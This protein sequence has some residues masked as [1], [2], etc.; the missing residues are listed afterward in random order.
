MFT[1]SDLVTVAAHQ[2][3]TAVSI[4][5]P[6]HTSGSDVR[7]DLIRL[8]NLSNRARDLL[9]DAGHERAAAEDILRPAKAFVDDPV[10][11]QE[12][13]AGFALFL[14]EKGEQARFSVPVA[15]PE[16]V[17]VGTRFDVTP[18]LPLVESDGQFLVLTVTST[19]V[20][21]YRASR[22]ELESLEGA[23]LPASLTESLG[24]VEDEDTGATSPTGSRPHT[25][26]SGTGTAQVYGDSPRD[27]RKIRLTEFASRVASAL[28]RHVGGTR[29][30]VVLV[31]NAELAGLLGD[32][33][34]FDEK[35]ERNP[36]A[37]SSAELRALAYGKLQDH[38]DE[39]RRTAVD[40]FESLHGKQ[41][42]RAL[43]SIPAITVAATEG[44]VD[45]LL[46]RAAPPTSEAPNP[47]GAPAAGAEDGLGEA[48]S[49]T[50]AHGGKVH[51][52]P[53]L[54]GAPHASAAAILRY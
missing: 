14:T 52:V 25:G 38:L 29:Q 33:Y 44:R 17:T 34:T 36:E 46:V 28:E 48:I 43:D 32:A 3:D 30:P 15:V 42:A 10:L 18:L 12:F 7:Q 53:V 16:S 1:R 21:L 37:L 20:C 26:V 49:A 47:A 45:T 4:Y 6:A 40:R 51:T 13:E 23:D 11:W 9:V 24:E 31:A 27:R 19:H 35:V 41:D 8:K 2:A 50:L 22:F 5:L 39:S 54:A